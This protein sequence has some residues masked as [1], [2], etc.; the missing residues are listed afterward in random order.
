MPKDALRPKHHSI[1]RG[2]KAFIEF[3]DGLTL[4]TKYRHKTDKGDGIVTDAGTFR[5]SA[6]R[7][8]RRTAPG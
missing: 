6:M 7:K 1:P 2:A 4:V 8:F 5:F 3:K